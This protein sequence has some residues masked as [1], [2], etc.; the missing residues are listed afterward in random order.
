MYTG[1]VQ[2]MLPIEQLTRKPGLMSFSLNFDDELRADLEQG[3]SVAVNGCCFTV[4]DLKGPL[5]SFDAIQETL[6]LTNLKQLKVGTQVN[7]ERSAKSDAEV[8]GHILSGHIVDTARV[9]DIELTE[10]NQRLT[11]Q[12]DPSWL[13]FVFNKGYLAVNGC[14]LTVAHLDRDASTFA[15]NLIPETLARTNFEQLKVG[16]ELNIEVESQTQV[17]VETVERI[18]A[19]RFAQ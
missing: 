12:G 10:N 7:I 19:E 16:D 14:S 5:V 4:T 15:I 6:D 9:I 18:M 8:G 11:C 13:K 1:I 17:I 2:R 3:A